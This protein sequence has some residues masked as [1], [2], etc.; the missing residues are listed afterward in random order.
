[1]ES[2]YEKS[3]NKFSEGYGGRE[4]SRGPEAGKR[5]GP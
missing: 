4:R 2:A 1:M 3:V 5:G